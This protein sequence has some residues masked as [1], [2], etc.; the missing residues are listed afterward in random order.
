MESA[1][2]SQDWCASSTPFNAE[3]RLYLFALTVPRLVFDINDL[4]ETLPAPWEWDVKRLVASFVLAARANGLASSAGREAAVACARSYR[5]RMRE[6]MAMDVLDIW[7]SR[8]EHTDYLAMLPNVTTNIA[9]M[10][11]PRM[12][13]LQSG[14][15]Q[16]ARAHPGARQDII[17]LLRNLDAAPAMPAPNGAHPPMIECEASSMPDLE[18]A[19]DRRRGRPG[20]FGHRKF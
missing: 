18:Y 19:A 15:L 17:G 9:I 6:L 11:D 3:N 8:I 13:E 10:S 20:G 16:I 5:K 1:G 7:Y 4:D 2:T 12:I 14:L